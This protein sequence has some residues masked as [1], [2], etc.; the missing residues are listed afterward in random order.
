MNPKVEKYIEDQKAQALQ[1]EKEKRAAF[2]KRIGMTERVYE[3]EGDDPEQFQHYD[4]NLDKYYAEVPMEVTEEEY[5]ALRQA[6]S[7]TAKPVEKEETTPSILPGILMFFAISALITGLF[8]AFDNATDP[9]FIGS[10]SDFSLSV[11]LDS[12]STHFFGSVLI[13]CIRKVICLLEEIRDK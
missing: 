1:A 8:M 2:L 13:L 6:A 9:L 5:Q 4:Y 12:F 11:F 10:D 7:L 3:K